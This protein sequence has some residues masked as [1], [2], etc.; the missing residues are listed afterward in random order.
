MTITCERLRDLLAAGMRGDDDATAVIPGDDGVHGVKAPMPAAVLVGLIERADGPAVVL[1][2]RTDHLRDHAGQ[3]SLPGG[4]IEADDLDP[5]ACALREAEEEVGISR[6]RVQ[7]LGR[8]GCYDTV[9]GYRIHPVVGWIASPVAYRPDPFEVAEVFELPL[10]FV[11]D[12]ANH[13]RRSHRRGGA[14]RHFYVL[15]YAERYIWGATAGILVNLARR[16]NL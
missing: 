13:H 4:R 7:V 2:Q 8:L 14:I 5:V 11:L 10:T 16:L 6:D 9:T 15:P 1:T 3:I 12:P